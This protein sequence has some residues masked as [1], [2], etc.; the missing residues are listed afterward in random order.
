ML[1]WMEHFNYE[2]KDNA[3]SYKWR[4]NIAKVTVC[5]VSLR[6]RAYCPVWS[7]DA[8]GRII[9]HAATDIVTLFVPGADS[10]VSSATGGWMNKTKDQINSFG[11][12]LIARWEAKLF[13]LYF[14]K[15][16]ALT[17]LLIKLWPQEYDILHTFLHGLN[18]CSAC[19]LWTVFQ[20]TPATP[21]FSV[22]VYKQEKI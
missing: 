14:S 3:V 13:S 6:L 9:S 15:L 22:T 18:K 11:R 19:T 12:G 8:I 16:W 4:K 10:L 17:K 1:F 21:F 7:I 2:L 5:Y 20:S